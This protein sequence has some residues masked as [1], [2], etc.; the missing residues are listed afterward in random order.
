MGYNGKCKVYGG[1][2]MKT[3]IYARKSTSKL[4]QSETIDNQINICKS[5]AK[6]L[7]LDVV[8]VKT[9]TGTG[10]DDVDRPEVLELIND[11]IK[12]KYNCVIMKGVSRFYRDTENGLKLIKRLDRHNI[13]V[14]T[15]EESFDSHE[16]RTG[17]GQLDTSRITMYLMFAEM[18]SKK[19]ADRVK[20]T[21][22]EKARKGEWN[23]APNPPYGYKYNSETKKLVIDESKAKIVREIFSLYESGIG[24]RN[25]SIQL[26]ERGIPSP[27]GKEWRSRRV[28][29]IIANRTYVG[30]VVF[31]M[32]SRKELIYKKPELH[33]K[34]IEDFYIGQAPN[35]ETK[36]V[37]TENAHEPII[38]REL[39]EKVNEIRSVK[40]TNKGIRREFALLAGIIKCSKCGKGM[41]L[42]KRYGAYAHLTPRYYCITYQQKGRKYCDNGN[43]R[44]DTVESKVINDLKEKY[45]RED[46]LNKLIDKHSSA[47]IGSGSNSQKAISSL[48]QKVNVLMNKMDK[49]LE[50]NLDGDISDQ[51]FK[52]MN[53]KYSD[54]L[55]I[56]TEEITLVKQ[57]NSI[58]S[59]NEEKIEA[60]KKNIHEVIDI[61]NK[62]IE[63]K[64]LIIMKLI[65]KVEVLLKKDINEYDITI[66]YTFQNPE[67]D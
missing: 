6:Q 28:Q 48:E 9:D 50:K 30:D 34:T 41:T 1:N 37:I 56:L 45:L 24:F 40:S 27:G 25:I 20:Y 17:T 36:W 33:Q 18:E 35:D 12:G 55:A 10:R 31:N 60:F 58:Q 3:C 49:L 63:G 44:M 57:K 62:D 64:R 47:I 51:Q 11:A 5:T 4:G 26:N 52:N 22:L 29:Y 7:G 19:T 38:S 53:A 65:S 14:V 59:S 46:L 39:F 21:Q 23:I 32:E 67:Q 61:D 13:R 2:V 42:K 43:I 54:E 15:V 66:H 8:D 16:Q